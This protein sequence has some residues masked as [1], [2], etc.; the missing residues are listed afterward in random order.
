MAKFLGFA[1][2]FVTLFVVLMGFVVPQFFL[3]KA[4]ASERSTEIAAPRAEIHAVVSDLTT[5]KEWTI[6]NKETDPT[7][8]YT[9]LGDAGQVGQSMKWVGEELGEGTM[10]IKTVAPDRVTY[11]LEF[12]G[13]AP[14]DVEM[15]LTEKGEGTAIRWVMSGEM[16]GPPHLRWFALM[17]D[18]LNGPAFEQGLA[19]LKER[20]EGAPA[21][22]G[23][24]A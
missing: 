22:E 3:D 4:Y 2:L 5:W 24:D 18:S 10:T 7:V 21:A 16:D 1:L 19:N 9:Y 15:E 11:T 20:F 12:A 13:M 6:W 17:M 23:G 8:E 14:C